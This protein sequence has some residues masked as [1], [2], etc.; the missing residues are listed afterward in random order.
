VQWGQ[1]L[2]ATAIALVIGYLV[3]AWLIRWVTTRSY[4]PFVI[5]RV[6]L[7]SVL[8]ILLAT[9]VLAAT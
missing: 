8:L 3:I 6:A 2:L 4:L 5:Y 9:G 7:G 1:T